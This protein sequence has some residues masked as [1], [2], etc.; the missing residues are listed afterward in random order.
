MQILEKH[1]FL[2]RQGEHIKVVENTP[3]VHNI[4]VCFMQ[5]LSLAAAWDSSHLV[6][7]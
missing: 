3:E 5:L 2:G 7:I 1:G 4:V 6:Q